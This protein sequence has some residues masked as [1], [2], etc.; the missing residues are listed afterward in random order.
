MAPEVQDAAGAGWAAMIRERREDR[1]TTAAALGSARA[2]LGR[3]ASIDTV[4][5][6][7]MWDS[8]GPHERRELY[9]ARFDAVVLDRDARSLAI[10]DAGTAPT[11]LLR[12]S[13]QRNTE[14]HPIDTPAGARVLPL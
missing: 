3:E 8:L 9:S 6:R 11:G 2:A 7:G 4:T 1:D 12:R 13:G 5:L 14:L 10:F